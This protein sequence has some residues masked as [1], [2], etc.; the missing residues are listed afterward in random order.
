L[1]LTDTN[2]LYGAIVVPGDTLAQIAKRFGVTL[3]ALA[4][5]N[6]II[7]TDLVFWGMT[8]VIP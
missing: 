8:L 5:A 4:R 3:D 7:N 1:A 6:N 2:A